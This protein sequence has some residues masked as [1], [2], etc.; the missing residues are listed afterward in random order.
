MGLTYMISAIQPNF[1]HNSQRKQQVSFGAIH[2]TRF[3]VKW[4]DGHYYH[5]TSPDVIKNLKRQIVSLLNKN[6]NNRKRGILS[7]SKPTKAWL[8]KNTLKNRLVKFFTNRDKDY[9]KRDEVRAF[10]RYNDNNKPDCYILTGKHVI[11]TDEEGKVIGRTT[12]EVNEKAEIMSDNLC[13]SLEEAKKT[14]RHESEREIQSAKRSFF[15]NVEA[16]IKR[17]LAIPNFANSPFDAFFVAKKKGDKYI[18]ELVDAK[19]NGR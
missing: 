2:Y 1:S 6:F 18:Y 3:F 12:R 8:K 17:V 4:E 9:E 15:D 14:I 13:I 7:P 5:A 10:T 11:I 19:I 16:E